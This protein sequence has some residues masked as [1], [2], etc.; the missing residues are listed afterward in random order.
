MDSLTRGRGG[1]NGPEG[2]GEE[3]GL[4]KGEDKGLEERGM[5]MGYE[6][7]EYGRPLL[8][9]PP[10]SFFLFLRPL[11]VPTRYDLSRSVRRPFGKKDTDEGVDEGKGG[12]LVGGE[13]EGVFHRVISTITTTSSNSLH[14]PPP[15]PFLSLLLFITPL[16][17]ILVLVQATKESL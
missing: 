3:D 7:G 5:M 16:P 15:L 11:V 6:G 8:L 12:C 1:K 14:S 4:H 13:E 2:D 17:T 9:I 10:S